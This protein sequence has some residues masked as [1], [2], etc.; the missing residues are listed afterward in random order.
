MKFKL[1]FN[2]KMEIW[3]CISDISKFGNALFFLVKNT[4][5]ILSHH[6]QKGVWP[7]KGGF[8]HYFGF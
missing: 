4:F 5:L 2:L 8:R 3:K 6:M 1:Y 7:K